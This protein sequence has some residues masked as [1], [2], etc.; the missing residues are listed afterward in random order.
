MVWNENIQRPHFREKSHFI[1]RHHHRIHHLILE[2]LQDDSPVLDPEL[3]S[4]G[5]WSILHDSTA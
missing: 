1:N 5:F 4:P 2:G 3:D